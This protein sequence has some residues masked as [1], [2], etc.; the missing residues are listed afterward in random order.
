MGDTSIQRLEELFT[1]DT[2][3]K[4]YWLKSSMDEIDELMG[5]VRAVAE[6]RT[7]LDPRLAVTLAESDEE[8]LRRLLKG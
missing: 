6:G 1:G 8:A 2:A 5:A 3:G 4:A 7:L